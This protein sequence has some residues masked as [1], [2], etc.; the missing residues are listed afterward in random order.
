M[1]RER[2]TRRA[3][4]RNNTGRKE[5]KIKIIK[6]GLNASGEQRYSL[7]VR[8]A[9][10]SHKKI[11]DTGYVVVERDRDLRRVYFVLADSNEGFKLTSTKTEKK[12]KSIKLAIQNRKEWEDA[13]GYYFLLKDPE[14][15]LYYI[16]YSVNKKGE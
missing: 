14:E 11:S 9:D 16:D 2:F 13:E 4:G 12:N 8:F 10:D 15:G 6:A 5:V 1:A 3:S 7:A